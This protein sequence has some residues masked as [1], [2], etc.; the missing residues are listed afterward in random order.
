MR[1]WT[2]DANSHIPCRSHAVPMPS[3]CRGLEK[4]LS[5][6]HIRGMAGERHGNGMV[7]VNQTRPHCVNQMGITQSKPLAERHGSGTAAEQQGNGRGTAVERQRNS[8]GT[9][10]EQQRNGIVCVNRPSLTCGDIT[11]P[12][13]LRLNRR[14]RV[15]P[16]V[17][18]LMQINIS[19]IKAL[20]L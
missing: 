1:L 6:R 20:L 4:S 8:R 9:A 19:N 15:M 13:S 3:P 12:F 17:L 11:S 14:T 2:A 7:C 5:E 16:P 18:Y 10:E